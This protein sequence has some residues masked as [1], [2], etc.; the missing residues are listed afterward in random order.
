VAAYLVR[1]DNPEIN[2][3]QCLRIDPV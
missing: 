2:L 1:I 3:V